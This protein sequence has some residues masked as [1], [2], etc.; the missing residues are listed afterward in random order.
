MGFWKYLLKDKRSNINAC[1][2]FIVFILFYLA[3]NYPFIVYMKNNA[4]E[5]LVHSPFYGVPFTLN[6]F[7]F[8]PSMY[9]GFGNASIIH[10]FINFLSGSLK[11]VSSF[12]Y[13]NAFFLVVQ[14]IIHSISVVMIYYY[15]RNSDSSQWIALVF[16]AFF[17]VSSYSMFTALIPDSYP[18]AQFVLIFSA[19]YLQYARAN[20]RTDIIPAALVA[21]TNFGVT[22]TNIVPF[23][24]ALLINM[25]NWRNKAFIKR[26]IW[27]G[28]YFLLIVAVVTLL[29]SLAGRSWIDNWMQSL[30]NGGFSYVAPFSLSQHWQVVYMLGINPIL[31]PD[32]TLVDPGIAAFVTNQMQPYP[33]YV[34]L[35]GA[36]VIVMAVLGFILH[37]RSKESWI[38]ASFILF[39]IA[40]HI[41]SGYGLAAFKYDL[42]L[43]A[44]HYL[45]AI[46]L[47]GARFVGRVNHTRIQKVL[48]GIVVM[49]VLLTLVHNIVQ[50]NEA[51]SIIKESYSDLNEQ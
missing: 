27:I 51:L 42:Y 7:N 17:G 1:G 14:S 33:F 34:T 19:L 40:L 39:A 36:A 38:F 9:Y 37:V 20:A 50:H 32:I 43:Y 26:F 8:D 6:L 46:F 49:F 25:F 41:V 2:L 48:I 18:Y 15:V 4:A 31:T 44:G 21:A 16:A 30:G 10:P 13:D 47:L 28:C 3:N 23:F 29:Q 24:A 12:L 35:I 45:F 22:S 5:L 11:Y